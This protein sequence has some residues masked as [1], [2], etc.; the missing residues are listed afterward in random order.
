MGRAIQAAGEL[1]DVVRIDHFR[2]FQAFWQVKQGEKTAIN[3]EW[4]LCP[5]DHFFHALEHDL[6]HLPVWAEDLGLVTPEVEKLRDDFDFPGMKVLQFAFDEKGPRIPTCRS[7]SRRTAS[8]TPGRT[9]TT[10]PS[11]GG[12]V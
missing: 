4:A 6:G 10:P 8:A 11:A 7:T 3:G 12:R 5:G 9:T 1:V 2:G